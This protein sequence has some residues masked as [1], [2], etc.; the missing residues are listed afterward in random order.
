MKVNRMIGALAGTAA[1]MLTAAPA[2]ASAPAENETQHNTVEFTESFVG[3]CDG[4]VGVIMVQGQEVFHLTNSGNTFQLHSIVN[5][6]FSIDFDDPGLTNLSGRFV[7]QHRVNFNDAQ[8]NDRRVT[9]TTRSVA[10]G[11]DG[12]VLPVQVT[13]PGTPV[14]RSASVGAAVGVEV[15]P[16]FGIGEVAGEPA[17]C[18]VDEL[19]GIE[20]PDPHDPFHPHGG[21]L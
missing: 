15:L 5:A 11:D 9:D 20:G 10:F 18:D 16:A 4:S 8:L 21:E 3:P 1:L 2:Q 14:R 12:T 7:G 17:P 19:V 6:S 13:A